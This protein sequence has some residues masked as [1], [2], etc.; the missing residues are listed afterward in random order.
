MAHDDRLLYEYVLRSN[1]KKSS[2]QTA[3]D[4]AIFLLQKEGMG[5]FDREMAA[6]LEQLKIG[7]ES[8]PPSKQSISL[9]V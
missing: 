8:R 4:R 7:E 6:T 3:L 1:V 9:L 5:Q 2:I